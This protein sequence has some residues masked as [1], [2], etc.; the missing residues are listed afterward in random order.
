MIAANEFAFQG[1][2]LVPIAKARG[3]GPFLCPYC[4]QA[5]VPRRRAFPPHF[6]HRNRNPN[7]RRPPGES[8]L[9]ALAKALI[10]RRGILHLPGE[11]TPVIL[12]QIREEVS[13]SNFIVDLIGKENHGR[14]L[15]VEITVQSPP[16]P[17]KVRFFRENSIPALNLDLTTPAPAVALEDWILR[18]APR[19]WIYPLSASAPFTLPSLQPTYRRFRAV[20][21]PFTPL[22]LEQELNLLRRQFGPLKTAVFYGKLSPPPHNLKGQLPQNKAFA[23]SQY[24]PVFY[25]N[26]AAIPGLALRKKDW[27]QTIKFTLNPEPQG[28]LYLPYRK[29]GV[30][31][32]EVREWKRY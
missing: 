10:H 25:W 12:E 30:Y 32:P 14:D 17:A 4:R 8:Q 26:R 13:L 18:S 27:G 23:Y 28:L 22:R 29:R 7:C 1:S 24:L 11:K 20:W 15:V 19:S 6:A 31:F 2:A 9:H 16:S 3:S 5:V 21:G